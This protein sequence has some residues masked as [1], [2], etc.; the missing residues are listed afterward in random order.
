M[1]PTN[2]REKERLKKWERFIIFILSVQLCLSGTIGASICS[3]KGM[4]QGE[5]FRGMAKE[6]QVAEFAGVVEPAFAAR[7]EFSSC[8]LIHFSKSER[9]VFTLRPEPMVVDSVQ[10]RNPKNPT[11]A[12]LRSLAFPGWGQLYN[13]KWIKAGL[14]FMGETGLVINALY[15][16]HQ[17]EKATNSWDRDFYRDNRNLSFWWLAAV[18]LLSMGDAYVDAHLSDFDVSTDL[19]TDVWTVGVKCRLAWGQ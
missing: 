19:S 2:K 7:E 9:G 14:V 15:W 4:V 3:G 1:N 5:R 16:D 18:V 11:G 17:A 10:I 13:G 12:M 8:I 6:Q